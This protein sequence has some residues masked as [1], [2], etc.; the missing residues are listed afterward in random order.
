M[1]AVVNLR[2]RRVF[3]C[4][5]LLGSLAC[6][7]VNSGM[8]GATAR[9]LGINTLVLDTACSSSSPAIDWTSLAENQASSIRRLGGNAMGIE[10]PIYMTSY[11]GSR[12]FAGCTG[13]PFLQNSPSPAELA[14][15]VDIAHSAGLSVFLRPLLA[16]HNLTPRWRGNIEPRHRGRWFRSYVKAILPYVDMA[17]KHQVE[18]F[19]VATEL[20]SLSGDSRWRR[21]VGALR[22][23]YPIGDLV[24]T[25]LS[26]S[27]GP[28]VPGSSYGADP[29][30]SLRG[31]GF[32]I[33]NRSTWRQLQKAFMHLMPQS[34]VSL[35]G[36]V[37][38]E[39]GI[40]ASKGA[41]FSPWRYDF[42]PSRFDANIQVKWFQMV[43]NLF[44]KRSIEGV[45]FQ[46]TIL[47]EDDGGFP[48]TDDPVNSAYIQPASQE[49]IKRCFAGGPKGG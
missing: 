31:S 21:V 9:Q 41:F 11:T 26:S 8:A 45:Y 49:A 35:S 6:C 40:S 46:G 25:Y 44:R 14:S 10:F 34:P 38:D 3:A 39:V 15:I 19:A 23:S 1:A 12:V 20:S 13:S 33:D 17:A 4:I 2:V 48:T 32:D 37:W 22:R 42:A 30:V 43:C 47:S 18:H 36:L 5:V 29:Y 24:M 28:E 27:P 16:Q 7:S